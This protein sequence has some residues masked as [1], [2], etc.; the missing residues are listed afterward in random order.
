[1]FRLLWA[2][3]YPG[4]A[5]AKMASNFWI[6]PKR[7]SPW[8]KCLRLFHLGT[9]PEK[10]DFKLQYRL[11]LL[12]SK[13]CQITFRRLCLLCSKP[14]CLCWI[15]IVLV[16]WNNSLWVDMFPHSDTLSRFW[17]NQSFLLLLNMVCLGKNKQITILL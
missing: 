1:M 13:N 4:R 3:L 9:H 16:Y 6:W 8:G 14:S 7:K 5:L 12:L 10:Q 2:N 15:F 17:A 11:P